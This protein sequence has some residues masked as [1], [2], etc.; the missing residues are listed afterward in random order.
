MIA[1]LS[2]MHILVCAA[3]DLQRAAT[4]DCTGKRVAWAAKRMASKN[5]VM[6][7]NLFRTLGEWDASGTLEARAMATSARAV[8]GSAGRSAM[9]GAATYAIRRGA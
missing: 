1:T 5:A 8:N 3:S 6:R 9:P 7:R 4:P 2:N